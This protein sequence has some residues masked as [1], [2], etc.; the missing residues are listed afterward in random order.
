MKEAKPDDYDW[1][2]GCIFVECHVLQQLSG[3]VTLKWN[4]IHMLLIPSQTGKSHQCSLVPG[5]LEPLNIRHHQKNSFL[6][7]EHSFNPL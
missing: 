2:K 5:I 7:Q 4:F 3:W 1:G 6:S